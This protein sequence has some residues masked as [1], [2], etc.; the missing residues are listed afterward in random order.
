MPSPSLRRRL[1]LSGLLAVVVLNAVEICRADD[2]QGGSFYT[3]EDEGWFFY[4][5][6]KPTKPTEPPAPT[7]QQPPTAAV[8]ASTEV[9]AKPEPFTVPWVREKME[10]LRD[11]AI[12]EPTAEN[13]TAFMYMQRMLLD[14]SSNF[15]TQG[16][17]IVDSDPYLNESVRFPT[18]T[19][20]R[21]S[22]LWQIGKA[23]NA[24]IHEVASRSRLW[25]FFDSACVHCVSQYPVVKMLQKDYGFKI[26][27]VSEDGKPLAG[28][29]ADEFVTDNAHLTFK[30]L[31]LKLTPA[32]VMAVPPDQ[33]LVVGHGAM[34]LDDM[35]SKIVQAS[36]EKD[37]VPKEL[38]DVV[39]LERKGIITAADVSNIKNSIKDTDDP[40]EL[41]KMIQ[42][43]IGNRME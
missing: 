30:Q 17:R 13:V 4:K 18:A 34:S 16:E 14:M 36:V 2:P 40:K 41:V 21:Q 25:F 20:S 9:K 29:G 39:Q 8:P 1:A 5:D 11:K 22:A 12:N 28:M 27:Y 7:P 37:L 31:G 15:A 43:A 38:T 19:A 23:K 3:R 33:L 35:E 10:L 26:L 6:R 24:V 42:S 32:V